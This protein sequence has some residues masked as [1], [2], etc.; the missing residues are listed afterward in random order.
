MNTY[1]GFGMGLL[2]IAHMPMSTFKMFYASFSFIVIVFDLLLIWQFSTKAIY[3]FGGRTWRVLLALTIILGVIGLSQ[4]F[5]LGV[6]KGFHGA[7]TIDQTE[8]ME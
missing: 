3:S 8:M 5:A 4:Q 6:S 2:S 1:I 7:K